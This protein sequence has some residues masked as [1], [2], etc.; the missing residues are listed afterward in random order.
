MF[1]DQIIRFLQEASAAPAFFWEYNY[2]A[3]RKSFLAQSKEIESHIWKSQSEAYRDFRLFISVLSKPK[4]NELELARAIK[5]IDKIFTS[6]DVED[7]RFEVFKDYAQKFLDRARLEETHSKK[8]ASLK[9]SQDAAAQQKYDMEL[10]LNE[11][12]SYS[13]EYYLAVHKAVKG[14]SSPE[15]QAAFLQADE[16]DLGFGKLPGL[17]VDLLDN[18]SLSKFILKILDDSAREKLERIYYS[19]R[20]AYFEQQTPEQIIVSMEE[21]LYHFLMI[22]KELGINQLSSKLLLKP[23][24]DNPQVDDLIKIFQ[25][26]RS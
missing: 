25:N 10:F 17:K 14:F 16:I 6:S 26:V 8:R 18:E 20:M 13:L 7:A 3:S 1:L 24:G 12:T 21:F 5:R 9:Q 19:F 2:Y 4:L 11:G 15:E 23:Y 22:F